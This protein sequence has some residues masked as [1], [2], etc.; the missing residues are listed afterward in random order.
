MVK[1]NQYHVA[2]SQN[3]SGSAIEI[4][5]QVLK[6]PS[7][8]WERR[9]DFDIECKRIPHGRLIGAQARL[10]FLSFLPVL[11]YREQA[12]LG[13]WQVNS[14]SIRKKKKWDDVPFRLHFRK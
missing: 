12:K 2:T 8:N 7:K 13:V 3:C 9:K 11:P 4:R 6:I 1:T 10:H 14:T 5:A